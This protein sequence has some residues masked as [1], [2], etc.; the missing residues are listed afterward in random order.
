MLFDTGF[1][2]A[3]STPAE[4]NAVAAKY[5]V[6]CVRSSIWTVRVM[7]RPDWARMFAPNTIW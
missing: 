2:R 4:S 6:P 5:H 7:G 3:L 1:V